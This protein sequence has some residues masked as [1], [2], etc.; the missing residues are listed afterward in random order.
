[1]RKKVMEEIKEK[2]ELKKKMAE[3]TIKY[4]NDMKQA[5][6]QFE[7]LEILYFKLLETNSHP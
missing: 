5:K 3:Q 1:M 7:G 6:Q 2:K 4:E